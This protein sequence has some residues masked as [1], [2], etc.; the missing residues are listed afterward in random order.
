MIKLHHSI[1]L[2]RLFHPACLALVVSWFVFVVKIFMGHDHGEKQ[3]STKRR[4]VEGMLDETDA[5]KD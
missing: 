2:N 3:R 4:H 5:S 1:I